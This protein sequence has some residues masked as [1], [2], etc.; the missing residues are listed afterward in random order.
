MYHLVCFYILTYLYYYYNIIRILNSILLIGFHTGTSPIASNISSS[1]S[2][3]TPSSSQLPASRQYISDQV[4]IYCQ[5]V[6]PTNDISEQSPFPFI[7]IQYHF[8]FQLLHPS[9]HL[10]S[11]P[12]SFHFSFTRKVQVHQYAMDRRWSKTIISLIELL[13]GNNIFMMKLL[14]ILYEGSIQKLKILELILIVQFVLATE[15]VAIFSLQQMNFLE[16]VRWLTF[17]WLKTPRL[18][19]VL[20]NRLQWA[21]ME[22]LYL[23]RLKWP[24]LFIY[25][26]EM[27]LLTLNT[28]LAVLVILAMI[29]RRHILLLAGRNHVLFP[30]LS[31]PFY[32]HQYFLVTTALIVNLFQSP[33]D[34]LLQ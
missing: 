15:K 1:I 17:A 5:R 33:P 32:L 26:I 18:P 16:P 27:T 28:N 23:N 24:I 34:L 4:R 14:L 6:D 21:K 3:P 29:L 12:N 2:I 11:I 10:K 19:T 7:I 9:R 13:I 25:D 8:Q 31:V 20:A 22:K 30:P